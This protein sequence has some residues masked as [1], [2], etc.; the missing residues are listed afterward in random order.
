[1]SIAC[2]RV[3]SRVPLCTYEYQH[4]PV[5]ISARVPA[6]PRGYTCAPT[7]PRMPLRVSVCTSVYKR[8]SSLIS[9]R[10]L[11]RILHLSLHRNRNKDVHA[12]SGATTTTTTKTTTPDPVVIFFIYIYIYIYDVYSLTT[13]C[14]S[15]YKEYK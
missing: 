1:M 4:V 5:C 15:S 12:G 11:V 7:Y 6:W 2:T 14:N 13:S 8:E 3:H 10:H 9:R